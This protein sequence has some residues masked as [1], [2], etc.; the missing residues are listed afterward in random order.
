MDEWRFFLPG[1]GRVPTVFPASD[2]IERMGS[3]VAEI[4]EA[5][6]A[7]GKA[8]MRLQW[9]WIEAMLADGVMGG[10]LLTGDVPGTMRRQ[11]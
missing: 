8:W 2:V 1:F 9:A 6:I 4:T 10:G 3:P 5:Q 11:R 7:L